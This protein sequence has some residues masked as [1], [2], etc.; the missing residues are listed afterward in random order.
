MFKLNFT[1]GF[2]GTGKSTS[3]INKLKSIDYG[4]ILIICPTHKA[5]LR[6]KTNIEKLS[7]DK[8]IEYRTVHSILKAIP[9][10]NEDAN[11]VDNIDTLIKMEVTAKQLEYYQHFFIDEVGMVPYDFLNE[12]LSLLALVRKTRH[13]DMVVNIYGDIYQLPPI[14]DKQVV[15][16]L[17]NDSIAK[18]KQILGDIPIEQ[19]I[20]KLTTQYR[21]NKKITSYYEKPLA[22]IRKSLGENINT[23]SSLAPPSD[24]VISYKEAVEQ[25]NPRGDKF[26]AYTNNCVAEFIDSVVKYNNLDIMDSDLEMQ[27]G[28]YINVE[29]DK[30]SY[31]DKITIF[32]VDTL[33]NQRGEI[34]DIFIQSTIDIT[35]D[36]KLLG[37][38]KGKATTQRGTELD[39]TFIVCVGLNNYLKKCKEVD[40]Q[41]VELNKSNIDKNKFLSQV[42]Y[43]YR[44]AIPYDF[45]FASTVHKAQGQECDNVYIHYKDLTKLF[46]SNKLM[47]YRL[48]YVASSRAIT[49]LYFIKD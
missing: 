26:L 48:L 49:N 18:L 12:L 30:N 38:I 5:L 22:W 44:L 25:F 21:S 41:L 10:I 14:K 40:R 39:G 47:F 24:M 46:Y 13:T 28:S 16:P 33:I 32:D 9:T 42:F 17:D 20:T 23:P 11:R 19:T 27:L 36:K 34:N 29:L 37:Y 31:R 45:A 15:I 6:L 43:P 3:L 2:A 35:N 4:R 1:I 8:T 7:I